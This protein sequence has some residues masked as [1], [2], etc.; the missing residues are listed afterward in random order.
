MCGSIDGVRL[1]NFKIGEVYDVGISFAHYLMGCGFALPVADE[2]PARVVLLDQ[3]DE[4][5][6]TNDRSPAD[7][8]ESRYV[9]GNFSGR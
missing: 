3:E 5:R 4:A 6:G 1:D 9:R 8:T 2:R 7:Q